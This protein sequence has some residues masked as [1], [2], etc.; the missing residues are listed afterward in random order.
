MTYTWHQYEQRCDAD[1]V[2]YG[3]AAV[4]RHWAHGPTAR[5]HSKERVNRNDLLSACSYFYLSIALFDQPPPEIC[6]CPL[7]KH[8]TLPLSGAVRVPKYKCTYG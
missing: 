3:D 7:S 8:D 1:Y 2:T 6:S 5:H 4:G